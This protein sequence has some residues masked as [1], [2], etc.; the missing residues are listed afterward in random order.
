[1]LELIVVLGLVYWVATG[2]MTDFV[3]V[4]KGQ[5]PP[6]VAAGR[7]RA[8]AAGRRYGVRG[9]LGDL[10]S[11]AWVQARAKREA[12]VKQRLADIEEHGPGPTWRQKA[13]DRMSA[14]WGR[15]EQRMAERQARR[16]Q[17]TA[18]PDPEPVAPAAPT[19]PDP[20]VPRQ[21]VDQD[22]EQEQT[23]PEQEQRREPV[24]PVTVTP[25]HPDRDRPEPQELTA[26]PGPGGRWEVVDT[27][28]RQAGEPTRGDG[29]MAEVTG[30]GTA[31]AFVAGHRQA[32]EHAVSSWEGFAASLQSGDVGGEVLAEC[33]RAAELQAEL[34]ACC[35]R[36]EQRLQAQ[37]NVRD[38]YEATPDAGSKEFVTSE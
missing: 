23:N 38:A 32:N 27:P 34:A 7:A 26:R 21:R 16:E 12:R 14:A 28:D 37:L 15:W 22:P 19:G 11:D 10:W 3:A 6:R 35:G 8:A 2:G 36:I 13:H 29:D 20:G 30:L 4:C 33:S 24:E 18:R 9:Y 1:M 31:I 5:T 17:A 25:W